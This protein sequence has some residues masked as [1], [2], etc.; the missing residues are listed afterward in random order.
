MNNLKIIYIAGYPRSGSTLLAR[1]LAEVQGVFNAGEIFF[2][3]QEGV[4]ENRLCECGQSFRDCQFWNSVLS[5]AF[6]AEKKSDLMEAVNLHKKI[7]RGSSFLPLFLP[8]FRT[9]EFTQDLHRYRGF[10][11][12]LYTAIADVTGASIIV[13]S[14]K[15]IATALILA[16][17]ADVSIVHLIRD[18]RGVVYSLQKKK[19]NPANEAYLPILSPYKVAWKWSLINFLGEVLTLRVPKYKRLIYENFVK[20]PLDAVMSIM[21]LA[22]KPLS[23]SPFQGSTVNVSRGHA[24]AGN[25][26][27]FSSVQIQ[28]RPDTAWTEKLSRKYISAVTV[29]T[30]PLLLRYGYLPRGR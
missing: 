14:S 24:V 7:N 28:I 25:P 22:G 29:L 13:D 23:V 26:D 21:E 4:I 12:Q 27:R 5:K 17:V 3:W 10:L 16:E 9:K 11:K 20:N 30:L 15:H 19:K 18:S 8:G 6:D 1:L 2:L